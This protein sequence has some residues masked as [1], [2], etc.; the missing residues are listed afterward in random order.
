M[1]LLNSFIGRYK[2][3]AELVTVLNTIISNANQM[4]H[5][6]AKNC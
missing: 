4:F 5:P 2:A 6:S 3:E 1:Y